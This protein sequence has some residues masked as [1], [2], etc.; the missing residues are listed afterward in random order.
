MLE[1][2]NAFAAELAA[3]QGRIEEA[4]RWLAKDGRNLTVDA[5]PMFYVPGL[6]PVKVL[7]ASAT[8][9]NLK[10]AQAWPRAYGHHRRADT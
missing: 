6:A 3:Q 4:L 9:G 10:A 7:I 8:E 1:V 5:T 2:L